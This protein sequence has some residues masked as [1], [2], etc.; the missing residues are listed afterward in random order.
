MSGIP[1]ERY[2]SGGS[3]RKAEGSALRSLLWLDRHVRD[4]IRREPQAV[5]TGR[6]PAVE[7]RAL[8][9]LYAA[10]AGLAALSLALPHASVQDD[11][12]ITAA[13]AAACVGALVLLF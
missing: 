7:A 5:T 9:Y 1:T 2:F 12:G 10:G 6:E 11:L 13:I 3:E 4:G 8:A